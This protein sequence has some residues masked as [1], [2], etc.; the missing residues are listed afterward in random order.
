MASRVLLVVALWAS[1]VA[2]AAAPA[3]GTLFHTPEE[4]ERLERMRRG[5]PESPAAPAPGAASAITGF[6]KR[7]DGR[8]TVWIDGQPISVRGTQ[9]AP[10]LDTRTVRAYSDR[11]EESLKI[12]RKPER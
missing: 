1:G 4:R 2:H 7:S 11:E 6:V 12:E 5:E 9:G 3:L 10:A 8:H